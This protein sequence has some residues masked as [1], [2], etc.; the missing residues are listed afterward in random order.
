MILLSTASTASI[1][2]QLRSTLDIKNRHLRPCSLF[3]RCKR[4]HQDYKSHLT[5]ARRAIYLNTKDNSIQSYSN[6]YTYSILLFSL[7]PLLGSS[8]MVLSR[9]FHPSFPIEVSNIFNCPSGMSINW[10]MYLPILISVW[11]GWWSTPLNG[12]LNANF[13]SIPKEKFGTRFCL[14]TD[15][16][17]LLDLSRMK[18]LLLCWSNYT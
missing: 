15:K 3:S 12:L 11:Y 2:E 10:Y 8:T 17:D 18:Q 4:N 7:S 9:L 14:S 16:A 1:L 13:P 5:Q 6:Q